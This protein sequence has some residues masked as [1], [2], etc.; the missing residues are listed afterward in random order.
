MQPQLWCKALKSPAIS[1]GSDYSQ[2]TSY[3]YPPAACCF[4]GFLR[5]QYI[6]HYLNIQHTLFGNLVFER[7]CTYPQHQ[8][9]CE[10]KNLTPPTRPHQ[11]LSQLFSYVSLS[12]PPHL[13][14]IPSSSC[15]YVSRYKYVIVM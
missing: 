14:P 6:Q 3:I 8:Q 11:T 10:M 4:Q 12:P 2:E 5:I 9:I 1:K 13:G 15:K 7:F